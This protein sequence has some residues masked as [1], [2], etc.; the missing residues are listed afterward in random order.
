MSSSNPLDSDPVDL[1]SLTVNPL[2]SNPLPSDPL[3]EQPLQRLQ[4]LF[5]LVP[6][7]GVIPSLWTLSRPHST[8]QQ[9]RV[10]RLALTLALLWLC[11][12]SLLTF[13]AGQT[14]EILHL[15]LLFLDALVTS[16]YFVLCLGLMVRLWKR[17]KVN[18]PGVNQLSNKYFS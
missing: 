2:P 6:V 3:F 13:S 1:D 12:Y 10:S 8:S 15:R 14:S 4:L 9:K 7:L 18:V 11:A 5:C 16:G 17:Q